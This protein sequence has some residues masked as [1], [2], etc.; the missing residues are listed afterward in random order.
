MSYW[1]YCYS[2]LTCCLFFEVAQILYNVAH[3]TLVVVPLNPILISDPTIYNDCNAC[4][5]E[6]TMMYA[7]VYVHLC[8]HVYV[9]KARSA[10]LRQDNKPFTWLERSCHIASFSNLETAENLWRFHLKITNL[11]LIIL[12]LT[13]CP[14]RFFQGFFW[15]NKSKHK[16]LSFPVSTFL[17]DTHVCHAIFISR[18]LPC[19]VSLS[20]PT[21]T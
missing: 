14:A 12:H 10:I 13:I 7:H 11:P 20:L 18:T 8:A 6:F 19:L 16:T 5:F 9:P 4:V 21:P 3:I 1:L 15:Q 17:R 2:M